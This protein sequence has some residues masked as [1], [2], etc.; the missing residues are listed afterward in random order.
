MTPKALGHTATRIVMS[1][2]AVIQVVWRPARTQA[3]ILTRPR[4]LQQ[5]QT[6]AQPSG[7]SSVQIHAF[8]A[9]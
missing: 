9:L 4:D 2:A 3:V 8:H 5:T 1:K 6:Y 7:N